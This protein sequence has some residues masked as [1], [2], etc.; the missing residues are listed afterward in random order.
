MNHELRE[1]VW[2]RAGSNCEYCQFPSRYSA[3]PFEVD[4]IIARKHHGETSESNLALSY[5]YC[6]SYKGPNIAGVD[7]TTS[8]TTP[9][10]HPRRQPWVE[11]F[12][13][14]G[15]KL[16]GLTSEGRTTVDVLNIN[17]ADAIQVR[18]ALILESVF[19]PDKQANA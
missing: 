16:L 9:L 7:P 14:D 13:W 15:A 6:N 4:H 5:F 3:L 11:H 8:K 2:K 19:P 12:R 10:F 1:F 18:S 17:L